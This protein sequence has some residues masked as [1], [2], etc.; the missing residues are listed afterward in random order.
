MNGDL[1]V[2]VRSATDGYVVLQGS[3][4]WLMRRRGKINRETT[5]V[6]AVYTSQTRQPGLG[7][8]P[9]VKVEFVFLKVGRA[10]RE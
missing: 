6:A 2:G 3:H 10:L 1:S 9:E 8:T 7:K 4:E 5:D